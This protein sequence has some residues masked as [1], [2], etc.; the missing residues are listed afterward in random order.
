MIYVFGWYVNCDVDELSENVKLKA[1]RGDSNNSASDGDT[2]G[3]EEDEREEDKKEEEEEENVKK[4]RNG[5]SKKGGWVSLA[6]SVFGCLCVD[7]CFCLS[8]FK[9]FLNISLLESVGINT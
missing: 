7:F 3:E 6:F 5:R 9:G 1:K 2:A 4:V 8:D